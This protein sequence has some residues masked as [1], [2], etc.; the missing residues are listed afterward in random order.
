MAQKIQLSA[1]EVLA[2]KKARWLCRFDLEYLCTQVLGYVD[3]SQRVHGGLIASLQQF[4][5]PT[6]EQFVENDIYEKAKWVYKP[7]YALK[8]LVMQPGYRRRLILD[9][10]GHLKT[11]INCQA[12]SMAVKL[13]RRSYPYHPV[14]P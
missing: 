7:V 14:Q 9:S 4:P 5:K 13:S 12:H 6:R 10:R 2:W 8:D 3:V 1:A 11:T